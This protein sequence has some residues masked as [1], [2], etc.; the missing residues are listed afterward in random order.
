MLIS[1]LHYST[2]LHKAVI[3]LAINIINYQKSLNLVRTIYIYIDIKF[4]NENQLWIYLTKIV[5][6]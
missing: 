5:V 2:K 3:S 1:S 4:Q 6:P